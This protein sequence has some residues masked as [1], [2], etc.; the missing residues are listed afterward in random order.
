MKKQQI[1]GF[2]QSLLSNRT[3]STY[4]VFFFIDLRVRLHIRL[5]IKL[6]IFNVWEFL[7]GF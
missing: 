4:I 5:K 7:S 2:L 1:L 6:N 3:I